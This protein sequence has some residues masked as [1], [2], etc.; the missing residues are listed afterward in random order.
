MF[1]H[2]DNGVS[3]HFMASLMSGLFVTTAM[4]PFDL[5]ATRLYNQPVIDV[6]FL[7]PFCNLPRQLA[8]CKRLV[9]FILILTMLS[10]PL[11]GK[12]KFYSGPIDCVYKTFAAEGFF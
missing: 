7:I 10:T 11:K 8:V 9:F 12:G 4:N 1:F 2:R 6:S 5:V 3:V